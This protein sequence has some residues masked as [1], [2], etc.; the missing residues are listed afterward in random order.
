MEAAKV[1][2]EDDP[3]KKICVDPRAIRVCSGR[4]IEPSLAEIRQYMGPSL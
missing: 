4:A 1:T 2:R 3:E